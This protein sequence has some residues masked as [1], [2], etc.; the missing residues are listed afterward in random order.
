MNCS[1]VIV[2]FFGGVLDLLAGHEIYDE[3]ADA[4]GQGCAAEYEGHCHRVG[5]EVGAHAEIDDAHCEDEY[6]G[7]CEYAAA[8][9]P[10][11]EF[12]AR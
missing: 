10:A 4:N 9:Q 11:V 1:R 2:Y 8:E 6:S 7:Q 12:L 5:F 3:E